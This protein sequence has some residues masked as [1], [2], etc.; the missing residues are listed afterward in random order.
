MK[1]LARVAPDFGFI[2]Y[3]GFDE[4]QEYRPPDTAPF[5]NALLVLRSES[6]CLRFARDRGQLLVD[7][8]S[9]ASGWFYLA[10]VVAFVEGLEEKSPYG[11]PPVPSILANKLA[12][13]WDR[14]INAIV[15]PEERLRLL[16]AFPP[17]SEKWPYLS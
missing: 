10:D 5:G 17:L 4:I 7:I 16:S 11:A 1:Q 3:K 13:L 12:H 9:I 2:I 14:T 8:G 15:D 6:V